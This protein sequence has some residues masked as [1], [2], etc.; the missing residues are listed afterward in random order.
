MQG[1]PVKDVSGFQGG[2]TVL[3][4][5][6]DDIQ[7]WLI[8]A[9]TMHCRSTFVIPNVHGSLYIVDRVTLQPSTDFIP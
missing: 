2:R 3:N 7:W 4:D 8:L 1:C 9:R 5:M 6:R